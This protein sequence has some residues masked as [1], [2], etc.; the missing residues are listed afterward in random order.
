MK[1]IQ[2]VIYNCDDKNIGTHSFHCENDSEVIFEAREIFQFHKR[3]TV[4][5]VVAFCETRAIGNWTLEDFILNKMKIKN[6]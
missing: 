3:G 2:Y 5:R 6:S 4:G 1:R